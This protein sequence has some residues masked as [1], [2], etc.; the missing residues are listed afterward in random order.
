MPMGKR[1]CIAPTSTPRNWELRAIN[2][3]KENLFMRVLD[4]VT[5]YSPSIRSQNEST[6]QP[7]R[8]SKASAEIGTTALAC[9]DCLCRCGGGRGQ[10]VQHRRM[11]IRLP[12]I[13]PHR[14]RRGLYHQ[15]RPGRQTSRP[16]RIRHAPR[17]SRNHPEERQPRQT[18]RPM[19]DRVL[20]ANPEKTA[21]SS[22]YPPWRTWN[23]NS[24]DS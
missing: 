20:L 23:T 8:P 18:H 24:R 15:A 1:G 2:P 5:H 6:S 13:H 16:K 22:T 19:H 4:R 10:S 11:L 7:T 17:P 3:V 14:S 21:P 9:A 12:R